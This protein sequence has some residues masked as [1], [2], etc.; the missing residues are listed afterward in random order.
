MPHG[1]LALA[2]TTAT[3]L[4]S[5]LLL[6]LMHR[7]LKGIDEKNILVSM[8]KFLAAGL[9]MGLLIHFLIGNFPVQQPLIRL[10]VF[11][12][13]GVTLY[14]L[15]MLLFRSEELASLKRMLKRRGS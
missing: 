8:G 3:L 6:Y 2:N 12:G 5:V 14:F 11:I 1:G 4:E 7:R 9:L 13:A 10:A 15:L